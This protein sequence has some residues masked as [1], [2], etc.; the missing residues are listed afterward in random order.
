MAEEKLVQSYVLGPGE[1]TLA[2]DPGLK[3]SLA[4]TGGSLTVMESRTRGGA[5]LHRHTRE[6]ECFYVVEGTI[7][8]RCGDQ[9][10]EAGPRSFVFLPCTIAHSWD[11]LGGG[12]ATVLIITVPAGF[13]EFMHAHHAAGAASAAERD[14]IAARYGIEWV[15]EGS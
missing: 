3:A 1:G 2:T 14:A 9:T 11:V 5:P 13:E 8:V 15:R 7:T 4:S 10:Y 12:T 6:D